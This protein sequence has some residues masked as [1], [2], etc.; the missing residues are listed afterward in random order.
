MEAVQTYSD[1]KKGLSYLKQ[2][3]FQE[4]L[5]SSST[6]FFEAIIRK[7]NRQ[8]FIKK[9][10]LTKD[11]FNEYESEVYALTHLTHPNIISPIYVFS[12]RDNSFVNFQIG[13]IVLPYFDGF[14]LYETLCNYNWKVNAEQ[15]FT[16]TRNLISA[17]NHIHEN[18]FFHRD[19]KLENIVIP[20]PKIIH[21]NS[22]IQFEFDTDN[23]KI[24]DFGS[25]YNKSIN[26]KNIRFRGSP[27]YQPP[28]Y[29][30]AG[31]V[32]EKFDIWSAAIMIYMLTERGFPAFHYQNST[33]GQIVQFPEF[34][35]SAKFFT[36]EIWKDL[37][38][39]LK[40]IVQDMLSFNYKLRPTAKEILER[41]NSI[42][43]NLN[44]E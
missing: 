36:D 18:G 10:D 20:K 3:F 22:T 38:I 21:Q 37:P 9:V 26:S 11:T 7:N 42:D 41:L 4:S 44:T 32:T 2:M 13:Y 33:D 19:L 31:I 40:E 8:V 43:L 6:D 16:F 29:I 17:I 25:S 23:F 14:D 27:L 28:E 1:F 5:N 34:D 24:I 30:N 39:K 15:L 35:N 12:D